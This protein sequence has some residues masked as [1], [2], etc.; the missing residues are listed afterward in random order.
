MKSVF[1]VTCSELGWD[2]VVGVYDASKV[3]INDLK[4]RYPSKDYYHVT[5]R[6]VE[7]KVEEPDED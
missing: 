1:V 6:S 4:L 2:C 5:E 3:N 7:I